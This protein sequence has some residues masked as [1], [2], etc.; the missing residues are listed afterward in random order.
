MRRRRGVLVA[1]KCAVVLAAGVAAV[2]YVAE[3]WDRSFRRNADYAVGQFEYVTNGVITMRQ[4]AAAAGIRRD[5]NITSIDLGAVRSALMKLPRVRNA[6]VE[7]RLPNHLSIR[8]EERLPVAWLAC[9]QPGIR[10]HDSRGILLDAEGVAFPCEVLL[11]EYMSLPVINAAELTG[12]TGGRPVDFPLVHRALELLR[13]IHEGIWPEPVRVEQI[14]L[15]NRFS[16]V[17]QT[18]QD[19]LF[20]FHPENLERQLARLR[21]ILESTRRVGRHVAS[22]NLQVQRNIPVTFLEDAE[23]RAEPERPKDGGRGR[24]PAGSRVRR[25]SSQPRSAA[26]RAVRSSRRPFTGGIPS[27]PA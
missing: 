4:V 26:R 13:S 15:T 12:V 17:V 9:P 21:A 7:R 14:H 6:E 11:N 18:D 3:M 20:T 25:V 23:V 27:P 10:S 1:L 8:L 16:L 24:L 19:A 22:V 5:Q 2:Q